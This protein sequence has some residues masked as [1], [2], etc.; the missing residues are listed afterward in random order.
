LKSQIPSTK[1]QTNSKSQIPRC[2][3]SAFAIFPLVDAGR[4]EIWDLELGICLGFGA[5][6][7]F[8]IWDLEFGIWLRL[9]RARKETE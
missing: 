9:G 6:D 1:S 4:C 2:Q 7:L 8:G 5:W 3:T